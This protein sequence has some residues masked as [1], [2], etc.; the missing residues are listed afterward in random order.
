MPTN[1]FHAPIDN[2]YFEDYEVGAQYEFGPILVEESDILAFA[3]KY[4][5]QPIHTDPEKS[6]EGPYGGLIASGWHTTSMMMR[7][8]VD[9]YLSS[10]ASLASPGVDEVR[11]RRPVRPRDELRL[12]VTVLESRPSRSKSDRGL[13]LSLMEAVD[14]DGNVVCSLR[15]MNLL[16]K[17]RS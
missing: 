3:R 5:P 13:V 1:V 14:Q 6:S 10:V 15:A 12:R 8:Y 2:R 4:D 7:L 11:W 17:R 16:L 9:N